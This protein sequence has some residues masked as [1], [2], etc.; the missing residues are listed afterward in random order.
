MAA[1]GD[2]TGHVAPAL[3]SGSKTRILEK[4]NQIALRA[5]NRLSYLPIRKKNA[6]LLKLRTVP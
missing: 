4:I 3:D 1:R 5:T 6:K 2:G